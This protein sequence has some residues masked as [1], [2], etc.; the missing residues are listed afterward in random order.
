MAQ[1]SIYIP[2]VLYECLNS[3]AEQFPGDVCGFDGE[4]KSLCFSP[5]HIIKLVSKQRDSQHRNSMVH[6]LQ[7]AVL[8][9]MGDKETCIFVAWGKQ[10]NRENLKEY[11]EYTLM[12]P[13]DEN[14]LRG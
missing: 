1:T 6:C 9:T 7:Q 3:G 11:L 12:K 14:N 4:A 8:S 5:H 13:T 10:K 2:G